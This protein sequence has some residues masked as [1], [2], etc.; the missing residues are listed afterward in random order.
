MKRHLL[1]CSRLTGF[2]HSIVNHGFQWHFFTWIWNC[3]WYKWGNDLL[4]RF[5]L[6]LLWEFIRA[7]LSDGSRLIYRV[8]KGLFWVISWWDMPFLCSAWCTLKLVVK[9]D[10]NWRF[11]K[12]LGKVWWLRWCSWKYKEWSLVSTWV[13][14]KKRWWRRIDIGG[15]WR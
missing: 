13:N 9:D 5:F 7:V 1:N 10:G 2:S 4:S 6:L 15:E 12:V 3:W 8:E 14:V 11:E